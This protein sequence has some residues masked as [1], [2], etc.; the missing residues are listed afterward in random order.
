MEI[1]KTAIITDMF[2]AIVSPS[3]LIDK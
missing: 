1:I 2:R 3:R